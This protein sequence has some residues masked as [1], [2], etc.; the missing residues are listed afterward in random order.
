MAELTFK[1]AGVSTREID[2]SGPTA[3]GPQ[4][5]PAGVVGTSIRGPAFV[6]IT[7]ATFQ[8]FVATFGATDGE[9]FGPI[10]MSEWMR[11]ARAGTFLKVLGAGD[12]N[13]RTTTG[14][15]IGNVTN[16]GFVA[17]SRQVQLNANGDGVIGNNYYAKNGLGAEPDGGALGRTYVLGAYMSASVSSSF[18]DGAGISSTY[19]DSEDVLGAATSS[20]PIVRGIVMAPSGVI[21]SLSGNYPVASNVMSASAYAVGAFAQGRDG[22][23][24][25]GAVDLSAAGD[26]QFVMFLNGYIERDGNRN[27][28]TASF[29]PAAPNYFARVFNTDPQKIE[30]KGHLLYSHYDVYKSQA[31]VTGTA[32]C[33]PGAAIASKEECAF[34][35]TSSLGRNVGST[36]IPNFENFEDRFQA[37]FSTFFTSQDLGGQVYNLFKVHALDDGTYSNTLFKISIA[38]IAKSTD[39]NSDYGTFDLLVRRFDDSDDEPQTLEK[40]LGLT[41]NP[42][43]DRYIARMIGDTN[44]FFDFD[45]AA[46]EQ[47]LVVDGVHPNRSAYIR[48]EMN[49][50]V[51]AAALDA[52]A[53]P[54][55][56][57]GAHH[58]VTSGSSILSEYAGLV[59]S[60]DL[61]AALTDDTIGT[62]QAVQPPVPFMS[63]VF[64]GAGNKKVVNSSLYWGVQFT[65]ND[66]IDEPNKSTKLDSTI[67][68]LTKYFPNFLTTNQNLLVGDNEGTA[69]SGG[70]IYDADR[71]NNNR[72]TLERIEIKTQSASDVVDSTQ[73]QNAIY[74]RDGSLQGI[75]DRFL[76]VEKDFGSAASKRYYKFSTFV[77]GGF[78]GV[79][80]FDKDKSRLNDNAAKREMSDSTNQGGTS[81]PTVA[82]YL[83]A[84]D[85]MESKSDVEVQLLTIPGIRETKITDSAITSVE[86]RFDA[87]YIM[88]I[89]EKNADSIIITSSADPVNVG[90][91]V[92]DFA[93]RNLDSSFA[94][95]YFP[96]VI[97]PDP[98]TGADVRCPPSVAALGAFALNDKVAFPWFAPAGFTRGALQTA[99]DVQSNLNR[100]NLDDLYDNDINPITKFPSSPEIVIFGQKTLQA[101]ESALDRVNVRRLLIDI[102]RKVRG[103]ANGI[104]F[105]P[106]REETLARFSAAVNPVLNR[107]QQQQGLDRFKVVI[108]ATTTTQADVEN[109]TIRGKIFLQ[110]TRSVE[111]ISLDFV[112]TNAGAEV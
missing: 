68:N 101:S 13:T 82:A 15:N 41:L 30:E 5:V 75:G 2:F 79:N 92:T 33:T 97:I 48:V 88:D 32:R 95:A 54:V 106:N 45:Q 51:D 89:E 38:N 52:K 17:G 10:A 103:I 60:G 29:N 83:K 8:D 43:S 26:E 94:A 44:T 104:L 67:N 3:L 87:L 90:N 27:L 109:N 4:G 19:I 80:I 37:P 46:G 62:A 34:L 102:R 9:K 42:S 28:V 71:F 112:V 11:N 111:F 59:D 16:A 31:V 105:E 21:L 78:D 1:S 36:A 56:F 14:D 81:G 73:W 76:N 110:P 7:V 66:N 18:F 49:P 100:A 57:R 6:P 20:H 23:S 91:T 58:L 96:D 50:D 108:D 72:F 12:G 40:F 107:I 86:N 85:I 47:K 65:V 61:A 69:D 93:S 74:R 53:L 55:G 84:L 24:P 70:T 35:V 64:I 98:T 63:G 39:P 22:G 25:L 99:I 77:Q